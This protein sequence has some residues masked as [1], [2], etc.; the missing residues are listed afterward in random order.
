M[1]DGLILEIGRNALRLVEEE[2]K[3]EA[4]LAPTLAPNMMVTTVRD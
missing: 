4:G 3:V 2:H 1:V